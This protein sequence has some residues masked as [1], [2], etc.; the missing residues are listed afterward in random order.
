MALH[1][2]SHFPPNKIELFDYVGGTNPI[3]IGMAVPGTATATAGW[4]LRK[5]AYDANG[6][7]TSILH[8]N[9]VADFTNVWDSRAAYSYS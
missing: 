8:A 4:Q 5:L 7:V 3:Y 6:N 2:Y 1:G 9:G